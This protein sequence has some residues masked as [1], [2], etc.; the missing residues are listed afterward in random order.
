MNLVYCGRGEGP[1]FFHYSGVNGQGKEGSPAPSHWGGNGGLQG[2]GFLPGFIGNP[3]WDEK[4]QGKSSP[5]T[6]DLRHAWVQDLLHSMA[7]Q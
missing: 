5:S 6:I 2:Q 4:G 7:P 3:W 1:F